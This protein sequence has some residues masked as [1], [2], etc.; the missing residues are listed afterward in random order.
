[1]MVD[2]LCNLVRK[3]EFCLWIGAGFSRYAGYPTASDL[4]TLLFKD[5][6]ESE[7]AQLPNHI[8]LSEF[9]EDYQTLRGRDHLVSRLQ[10]IFGKNPAQTSHH[11]LL[12]KIPHFST[13]I[14]TNYDSLIEDS[15]HPDDRVVIVGDTDVTTPCKGKTKVYKIHGDLMN[16]ES[17]IITKS[18]Y[19]RHYNRNFKEPF[20]A[21]IIHEISTKHI[22][23]LGYGYEDDNIWSDFDFVHEKLM[24]KEKKRFMITPN[25]KPLKAKKLDQKN[26]L[27]IAM[28]GN[29]FLETLTPII[30]KHLPV[31]LRNNYVS[32]DVALKFARNFDVDLKLE[33]TTAGVQILS[34]ANVNGPTEHEVNLAISD[35]KAIKEFSKFNRSYDQ[36]NYEVTRDQMKAF[37]LSVAGFDLLDFSNI[38]KFTIAHLPSVEGV[39]A[40]EFRDQDIEISDVIYKFYNDIPGKT[41]IGLELFGFKVNFNIDFGTPGVTL[42]LKVQ[43]PE[44]GARISNYLRFYQALN[45]FLDGKTIVIHR[46]QIRPIDYVFKTKNKITQ[47]QR[48]L[49]G[50]EKLREI[51]KG[52]NVSFPN[53]CNAAL[54]QLS[55]MDI[56]K[57]TCI[58]KQ[59]GYLVSDD[60]GYEFGKI[61]NDPELIKALKTGM[62]EGNFL[63]LTPTERMIF[64]LLGQKIDP[65]D[66]QVELNEPALIWYRP[67]SSSMLLKAIDNNF[68]F[69]FTKFGE[70]PIKNTTTIWKRKN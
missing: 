40:I 24:G 49:D 5:L 13:I 22:I 52:Y 51:E 14:T 45:L 16:G 2:E 30:R 53:V 34:I 48:H 21:S 59:G 19:S 3:E 42:S 20:W 25:L 4:Q 55:R 50:Y 26:I 70:S 37:S 7:R 65:G 64:S 18:D 54:T 1:M 11:E 23:F 43:E 36:L 61:P 15:Y 28:T 39:C 29:D 60:Q 57:L 38:S 10:Q 41:L 66:F 58:L 63:I 27:P 17:M 12:I 46:E 33:S 68:I 69:R 35:P 67:E 6:D 44:K 31:D 32:P 9:T 8:S 62:P 47:F 56:E